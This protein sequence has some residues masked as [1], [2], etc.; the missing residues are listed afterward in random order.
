MLSIK[1]SVLP[2]LEARKRVSHTVLAR[3]YLSSTSTPILLP[4]AHAHIH[5]TPCPPT[6]LSTCEAPKICVMGTHLHDWPVVERLSQQ[7]PNR[8]VPGFG[9]HPWF[10]SESALEST[11]S[12]HA[13]TLLTQYLHRNPTAVVGEVGLDR[14]IIRPKLPTISRF[15]PSMD[16]QIDVF[17]QCLQIASQLNRKVSIHSVR[18]PG[19]I[20]EI[21]R[22]MENPP[23]RITMHSWAGEPALVRSFVKLKGV[24]TYF[25]VSLKQALTGKFTERVAALPEDRIL[26]ESGADAVGDVDDKLRKI[27]GLVAESKG[28]TVQETAERSSKNLKA[29][30]AET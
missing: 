12:T 17:T 18:S 2:L 23:R 21:L 6:A 30:L 27:C 13:F 7:H 22:R 14:S 16:H 24:E 10:F 1:F 28:W 4:D 5:N 19:I 3:R 29:F 20:F 11:T 15:C 8:I 9:L 26:L 25:G